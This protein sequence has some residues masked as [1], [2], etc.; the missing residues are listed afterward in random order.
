MTT[1]P[2]ETLGSVP[3]NSG[4]SSNGKAFGGYTVNGK[5]MPHSLGELRREVDPDGKIVSHRVRKSPATTRNR[6]QRDEEFVL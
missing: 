2:S 1:K 5:F 3:L 4:K 6:G